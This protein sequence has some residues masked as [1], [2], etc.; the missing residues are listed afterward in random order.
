MTSEILDNFTK[1][2]TPQNLWVIFLIVFSYVA[3]MSLIFMYHWKKFSTKNISIKLAE[4]VYLVT[5]TV[6][7]GILLL[8]TL[9]LTTN[10]K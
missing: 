2:I 5:T 1:L 9:W 6:L 4:A 8:L 7:V 3:I 10:L